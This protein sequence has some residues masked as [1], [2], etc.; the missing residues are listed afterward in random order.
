MWVTTTWEAAPEILGAADLDAAFIDLQHVSYGLEAVERLIVA[1]DAAGVTPLVRPA[2]IESHEISRVLDAG[3]AGVIAPLV[4][5][6]AGAEAAVRAT[7]YPPAGT[8]GWGGAHTRYA[9][10]DGTYGAGELSQGRVPGGVYS[11]EYVSDAHD[12]VL[13]IALVESVRGVDN[14]VE[15]AAV[16]GLDA[17]IFGLGDFSVEVGFNWDRCREAEATVRGACRSAGVGVALS[18]GQ[19]AGDAF[20][21]G[22]FGI[23][24]C[25]SLLMAG[26]LRASVA[27]ARAEVEVGA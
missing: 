7:R 1:C 20:Y 19:L 17:V 3:A 2:A 24:G 15:I 25:D 10:F 9:L 27:S 5:D 21:P 14:V 22:C 11:S 13:T 18:P 12:H 8:R 6:A 23:V 16:E 4:E 26:A